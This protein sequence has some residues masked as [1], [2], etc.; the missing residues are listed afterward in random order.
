MQFRPPGER[1]LECSTPTVREGLG[2]TR[3]NMAT[4]NP[5]NVAEHYFRNQID[6][7]SKRKAICMLHDRCMFFL[8]KILSTDGEKA[9]FLIKAQ[10]ILSQLQLSLLIHDSVSQ[11]LFYLYDYCYLSLER[12]KDQDINNSLEIIG[13]LRDTFRRLSKRP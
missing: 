10:N 13:I 1:R 12:G 6:T 3:S 7:A 5:A 9:S 2:D 4:F 8:L 11:S